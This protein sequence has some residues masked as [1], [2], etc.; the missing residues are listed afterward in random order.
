MVDSYYE[1]MVKFWLQSGKHDKLH[2]E[3]ML[4]ALPVLDSHSHAQTLIVH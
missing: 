4:K 2:R 3:L 1:Y